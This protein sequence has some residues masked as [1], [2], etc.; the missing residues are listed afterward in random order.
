MK[1][2]VLASFI[3]SISGVSVF[4]ATLMM[5]NGVRQFLKRRFSFYIFMLVQHFNATCR[6]GT[7]LNSTT[8]LFDKII[9]SL[10]M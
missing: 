10:F 9:S 3:N 5:L 2:R 1:I 7:L 8:V 4:N 6:G